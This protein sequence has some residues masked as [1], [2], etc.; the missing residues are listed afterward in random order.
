ME[1]LFHFKGSLKIIAFLAREK[2]DF[3]QLANSRCTVLCNKLNCQYR[4]NILCYIPSKSYSVRPQSVS[5]L[6][7]RA[8]RN[9][10]DR[11]RLQ[12]MTFSLPT[13]QEKTSVLRTMNKGHQE[14]RTRTLNI[15]TQKRRTR[16]VCANVQTWKK[17]RRKRHVKH[18]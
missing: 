12:S 16:T 11:P 4:T 14:T 2:G 8:G 6:R 5:K 1:R 17:Y 18:M 7:S 10:T 15:E 3:I 13:P 9:G